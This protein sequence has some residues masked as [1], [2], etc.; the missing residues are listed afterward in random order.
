MKRMSVVA[1]LLW[2][3]CGAVTPQGMIPGTYSGT[4]YCDWSFET[5]DGQVITEQTDERIDV[6]LDAQGRIVVD[7]SPV[8]VGDRF[9]ATSDMDR[10]TL[11]VQE[12]LSLSS[13]IAIAYDT[14]GALADGTEI[15]GIRSE[16]YH[17]TPPDKILYLIESSSL[18]VNEGEGFADFLTRDCEAFLTP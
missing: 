4:L 11:V 7:G 15:E 17:L 13:V 16:E 1:M 14:E 2:A 6:E 10:L 12:V 3:G 9:V 5:S 18:G 8:E